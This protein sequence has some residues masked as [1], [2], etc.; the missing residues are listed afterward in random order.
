MKQIKIFITTVLAMNLFLFAN[1]QNQDDMKIIEF[2]EE[3]QAVLAAV[4]KMTSAFHNKDIEGVMKSYESEA[5]VVFEPE[6]PISDAG[7]LKEMFQ[8]A[9][10]LNP[11]FTYSGHEV[12][13]NGDIAMHIAPWSMIGKTPEGTKI[14][15]NG[16]SVAIL[17]KQEN[18]G[19]LMIFD[20]PH[21][22]FLMN[23]K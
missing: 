11:N 16:L 12:F 4:E 23:Q 19:W 15:Q 5:L 10:T 6:H 17:R 3:Q 7:V 22:N 13:I 20:N 9:F 18:G 8:G 21:G 1:A 2:N 14:E